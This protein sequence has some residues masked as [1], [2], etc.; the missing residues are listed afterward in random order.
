MRLDATHGSITDGPCKY[1]KSSRCLWYLETPSLD[2]TLHLLI[3]S[4][5]LECSWDYLY[6]FSGDSLYSQK[7]AAFTGVV[8]EDE[9]INDV[10][11][12]EIDTTSSES[13]IVPPNYIS[14]H[15]TGPTLLYFF[16]DVAA[17]AQG[18]Y[19]EYWLDC[20]ANC[21]DHGTCND[22]GS[23]DCDAG[24]TGEFC[25]QEACPSNCSG[26]G[27][28]DL[29][30][31]QCVCNDS[32]TG[33][34][35]SEE[36]AFIQWHKLN[37]SSTSPW[38]SGSHSNVQWN[39]S[40]WL[41]G[42]YKF[43]DEN[44][45]NETVAQLWRYGLD[46]EQAM[47]LIEPDD[48]WPSVRYGHS[49]VVYEDTMMVFG[50]VLV[51]SER[52]TAELWTYS[53]LD[54]TWSVQNPSTPSA[55]YNE[56]SFTSSQNGSSDN[57]T[58]DYDNYELDGFDVPEEGDSSNNGSGLLPLPVRGHTAHVIGDKMLVFFGVVRA[59]ESLPSLI[60][61]LDLENMTWSVPPQKGETPSGRHGHTSVYLEELDVVYLYG[62]RYNPGIWD[63]LVAF[64]VVTYTWYKLQPSPQQLLF[65]S[66]VFLDHLMVVFGGTQVDDTTYKFCFSNTIFTYDTVCKRWADFELPGLSL[67]IGRRGHSAVAVNGESTMLVFGGYDGQLL[68]DVVKIEFSNCTLSNDN[69]SQCVLGSVGQCSWDAPTNSCVE[70]STLS[71]DQLES[72][73]A[74][75]V[76][77]LRRTY[78]ECVAND[79]DDT[80]DV[81]CQWEYGNCVPSTVQLSS[82]DSVTNVTDIA[83]NTQSLNDTNIA[84][85][86]VVE[87]IVEEDGEVCGRLSRCDVCLSAGCFYVNNA[88]V[89]GPVNESTTMEQCL[90]SINLCYDRTSCGSCV[91]D[92]KCLWCSSLQ[93][94]VESRL[95][96]YLYPYGQCLGWQNDAENG[97]SACPRVIDCQENSYLK[98][99]SDIY[100]GWCYS[101]AM[102][103]LGLCT[104]GG[105]DGPR[106]SCPAPDWSWFYDEAPLCNCNGHSTC[107]NGS[108]CSNCSDNTAGEHC[109]YCAFGFTGNPI[110]G[111]HCEECDCNGFGVA[112]HNQTGV[113]YCSDYGVAG[114]Y[115]TNCTAGANGNIDD[116]CYYKLQ[117]GYSYTISIDNQFIRTGSFITFPDTKDDLQFELDILYGEGL[118]LTIFAGRA[119][120]GLYQL[121]RLEN[122]TGPNGVY[123]KVKY[124]IKDDDFG[125]DDL[126]LLI[127]VDNMHPPLGFKIT[128]KQTNY[129]FLLYFFAAFCTCFLTLLLSFLLIWYVRKKLAYRRFV[130]AHYRELRQRISRPFTKMNVLV[131]SKPNMG[132]QRASCI[133]VEPCGNGKAAVLSLLVQ[134]PGES[135][136]TNRPRHG[137]SGLCIGSAL[138]KSSRT[139]SEIKQR[140]HNSTHRNTQRN[141]T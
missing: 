15:V 73:C 65:H 1:E 69:I 104:H 59:S 97:L 78:N 94:C 122:V 121:E 53:F 70:V 18:F 24:W 42:G 110:N 114:D 134:L 101:P 23:C 34:D 132:K 46:G 82:N 48:L 50:G 57:I 19:I 8:L 41:F 129:L 136:S 2:S 71:P 72:H 112:C 98:C 21:S 89:T 140:T 81:S 3:H 77:L 137:Q 74:T 35:C 58:T 36:I 30:T 141:V 14:L 20:P 100:C 22:D 84:N 75:A 55:T 120:Q 88:C 12:T 9:V 52:F 28:C 138:V 7:I 118:D 10:N 37:I 38:G 130:R 5:S 76:C 106:D 109:E 44:S 139:A 133:G 61:Q 85:V 26:N 66:A 68:S 27:E 119:S 39:E 25:N 113:C 16:S 108:V 62:G 11:V 87:V 131:S 6:V 111:N 135:T 125:D 128:L 90:A 123:G 17:E 126:G 33:V 49:A 29:Q 116:Y 51:P 64:N 45:S 43:P 67:G 79:E 4:L 91:S 56:T 86:T 107:E 127:Y 40:L 63:D 13:F 93:R 92:K 99:Q 105:F 96:P 60:Q 83:N 103:G 80:S 102:T 95:Y 115:C 47:E 124:T 117:V 32:Y 31:E 54:G